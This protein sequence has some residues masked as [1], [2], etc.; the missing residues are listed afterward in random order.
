MTMRLVL[1]T[2]NAHKVS[3]VAEILG[4]TGIDVE[5]TPL[6]DDAP[7]VVEDGLTFAENALKKARAAVLVT[8]LP[9]VADDS[10]LCVDALNGMPGVFSARWAGAARDDASNLR[11]VLDQLSDVPDEHL[12]A[13]FACAAA[14]ALPSGD[15]RVVEGR[16]HGTLVRTPRGTGG[17][18]YDPVFLPDGRQLTMAELSAQEKHAISHRGVAF[19]GLAPVL[20]ELLSRAAGHP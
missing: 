3:E 14:L 6:P 7:D 1:A 16:V 8:G 9:A 17:F 20:R 12:G 19:R 13:H 4:G 18:G 11:L 2:R 5:L 10:G 15:E